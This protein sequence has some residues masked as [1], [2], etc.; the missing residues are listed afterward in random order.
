MGTMSRNKGK[1]GEREIIAILQ[2]VVT[3]AYK[4]RGYPDD[5]VPVLKRNTMQSDG[6]GFDIHG[7]EWCAL[8]VKRAETLCLPA[9]WRQTL[10]Q[11]GETK[12]PVLAYRQNGNPWRFRMP[13]DSGFFDVNGVWRVRD[14]ADCV[15]KKDPTICDISQDV[16]ANY[17]L[18]RIVA[19]LVP[20]RRSR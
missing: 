8:E 4:T 17:V 6:G 1:R 18:G 20:Y 5:W 10:R 11:A 14:F 19:S 13:I 16:F 15:S 2:P 9:W 7:L 12:H 3:E